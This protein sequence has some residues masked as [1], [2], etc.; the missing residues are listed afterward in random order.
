MK[1]D[2]LTNVTVVDDTMRFVSEYSSNKRIISKK[3]GNSIQESKEPDYNEENNDKQEEEEIQEEQTGEM[4]T[5]TIA[6]IGTT[7]QAS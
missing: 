5:I 2:L 4:V 6:T 1:V 7:T 3:E